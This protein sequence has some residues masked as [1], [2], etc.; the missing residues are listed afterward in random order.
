MRAELKQFCSGIMR[1]SQQHAELGHVDVTAARNLCAQA[2]TLSIASEEGL[3]LSVI[4]QI[5]VLQAHI[6]SDAVKACAAPEDRRRLDEA[7]ALNA[8]LRSYLGHA[9]A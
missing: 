4:E 2:A 5:A 8:L 3:R 9:P 1:L 7:E 6:L